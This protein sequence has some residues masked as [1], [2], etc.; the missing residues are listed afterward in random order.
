MVDHVSRGLTGSLG[1]LEPGGTGSKSAKNDGQDDEATEEQ[2][3]STKSV[4]K[5]EIKKS[6]NDKYDLKDTGH[7]ESLP[8]RETKVL[9][10]YGLLH[11]SLDIC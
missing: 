8:G 2:W 6:P 7:E 10:E 5:P 11:L 1:G 9:I 4:N 3:L